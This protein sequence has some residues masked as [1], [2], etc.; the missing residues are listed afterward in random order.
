[1]QETVRQHLRILGFREGETGFPQL[2]AAVPLFAQDPYQ[3]LSKELQPAVAELCHTESGSLVE[4][5]I[6]RLI[7][8]TWQNRNP[9]IW[10]E[11]F[12]D[13]QEKP[14]I[15]QFLCL[16]CDKLDLFRRSM[17]LAQNE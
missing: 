6:R 15:H 1:M 16:L 11:Y 17:S 12:P 14:T 3:S 10:A 9:S 5:K 4:S 8:D 13:L 7:S 2:C